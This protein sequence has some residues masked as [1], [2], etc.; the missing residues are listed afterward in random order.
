MQLHADVPCLD[1]EGITVPLRLDV[2]DHYR[3]SARMFSQHTGPPRLWWPSLSG[4]PYGPRRHLVPSNDTVNFILD[5]QYLRDPPGHVVG[6]SYIPTDWLPWLR[7]PLRG[8]TV[9]SDI[10]GTLRFRLHGSDHVF[11]TP[12]ALTTRM[13]FQLDLV[14]LTRGV[15]RCLT[16]D[17]RRITWGE[18]GL[19]VGGVHI[20]HILNSRGFKIVKVEVLAPFHEIVPPLH[21]LS[22][23]LPGGDIT[24]VRFNIRDDLFHAC[25]PLAYND[26][27]EDI[28]PVPPYRPPIMGFPIMGYGTLRIKFEGSNAVHTFHCALLAAG[29]DAWCL[30]RQAILEHMY[31]DGSEQPHFTAQHL[32]VRDAS[33][34]LMEPLSSV[35]ATLLL[36]ED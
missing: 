29:W 10:V 11:E 35:W 23:P 5:E 2:D 9:Q 22:G 33:V 25:I 28:V 14:H 15:T 1:M 32:I 12:C 3:V 21:S 6:M 20:P 13:C 27:L 16:L 34:P 7:N 19:R 36:P 30:S 4:V 8:P 31:S 17:S 18:S 26:L 24:R